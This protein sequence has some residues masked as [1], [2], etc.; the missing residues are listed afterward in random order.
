MKSK[1]PDDR[2]AANDM[3]LFAKHF[4]ESRLS[5][6]RKEMRICL[7]PVASPSRAGGTHAYF[8]ALGA[9]CGFLEY[10]AALFSGHVNGVGWQQVA[11]WT[12]RFMPQP[13]YDRE[14]TRVFF[15]AFRHSVAHRGIATGIW[16]DRKMTPHNRITW[17]LLADSRRP[18]CTLVAESG[19]LVKDP[20]WPCKYTHRMHIHLRGLERDLA[21][22]LPGYVSAIA[23]EPK[24]LENFS[25]CMRQLYPTS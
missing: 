6:Y 17:K 25:S 15:S 18:A 24:L 21:I 22:A 8:A 9:S 2:N 19:H 16:V 10:M 5:G 23:T 1:R 14:T 20:P 7:T 4:L 11:A 13:D 3:A 12:A